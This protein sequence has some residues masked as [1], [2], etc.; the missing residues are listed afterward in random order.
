MLHS[1]YPVMRVIY[2]SERAYYLH[3]YYVSVHA[4]VHCVCIYVRYKIVG[5]LQAKLAGN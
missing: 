5:I 1:I 2:D 3:I 4:T